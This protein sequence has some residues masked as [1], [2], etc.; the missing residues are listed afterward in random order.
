[1][2][3]HFGERYQN[4]SRSAARPKESIQPNDMGCGAST[5]AQ[6]ELA[7][8]IGGAGALAPQTQSTSNEAQHAIED[9]FAV[10]DDYEELLRTVCGSLT[11]LDV[12]LLAR[13]K[14]ERPRA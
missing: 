10:Y 14:M 5:Q 7:R 11:S 3:A 9:S 12:G 8:T 1:M 4:L 13:E 2:P 6:E